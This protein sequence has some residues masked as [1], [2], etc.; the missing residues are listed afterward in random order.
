MRTL[1]LQNSLPTPRR[2]RRKRV[3]AAAITAVILVATSA[4]AVTTVVL[5]PVAQAATPTWM[6]TTMPAAQRAN[7]L[8]AAMTL[9]DKISM[10]HNAPNCEYAGCTPTSFSGGT[11]PALHLQD[12][13]LGVGDGVQ[14]VTQ[15]PAPVAGAATWDTALMR[16]YGTLLG[17][18]HWGKGVNVV[19]GP[20]V[21]IVRD[22]RWGRAFESFGEDPYLAGHIGA[23]EINGIQAEG[24]LAQVKHFVAYNQETNRNTTA[25]NVIASER[26]LREIY[27]PAFEIAI[28]EANVAS[29]MCSY[30]VINGQF[31]CE[32]NHLQ[33]EVLK[34]DMG[35]AGFITA[36]WGGQHSTVASA[37]GGLDMEM[38]DTNKYFGDALKTAVNNGQVSIATIDDHVRRILT[39]MFRFGLF[40]KAQTGNK[41][42]AVTSAAHN[43]TAKKVAAEG[44]VLLKNDGPILPLT[45]AAR[46]IAVIGDAG[47][48]GAIFQGGGS[49]G[50]NSSYRVTPYD[51]IKAR[52]GSG[53]N[54]S[55]YGNDQTAAVAGARAADVAI[56]FAS[57]W[58][59]EGS[60]T[61]DIE[62]GGQNDLISAVAAAN[63]NTIVV[64]NT[65]S[66]VTMPWINS[67]KGVVEAW[68]GGQEYGNALAAV[69][70]GDANP[71]GKLPVTFPRS[72]ADVPANTQAQWPG[73][74]GQVQYSEG[75]NVGYRSYDA[76]NVSPLFPFGFGLSYT[77]FGYSSLIVGQPD[78][79]GNVSVRF[80]VTNT[81]SRAGSEVPQVYVGQPAGIGEPPKSLQGFRKV[82]LAAGASTE[83]NVTLPLRA[84]QHWGATGWTTAGGTHTVSVGASSRDLRINGSVAI[85]GGGGTPTPAR[86]AYSTIEAESFDAQ[87]GTTNEV[88]AD[89]G[90]GQD[91]AYIGNGDTLRFDSID[92]GATAGTKVT[93][94]VA[95]AAAGSPAGTIEVRLDGAT[96]PIAATIP[97][98]G[99]GGWQTWASV[100]AALSSTIGKHSVYL[101]FVTSGGDFVNINWITFGQG[102]TTPT[103]PPTRTTLNRTGW[104]ASASSSAGNDL[105]ANAID[106]NAGSRWSTGTP[107]ANGQTFTVDMGSAKTFDQVSVDAGGSTNDYPRGV[108]VQ[109]S[110]NGTTWNDAATAVAATAKQTVSF[111]A[112]TAQYIRVVQTGVNSSWWSIAELNVLTTGT[113]PTDPTPSTGQ[114]PRA[115]WVASANPASGE[116]PAAAI[117]GNAA[118]RFSSGTA[119][120]NGQTFT[121]DMG[122]AKT[123]NSLTMDSAGSAL[124]YA[125]GYTVQVSSD[126]AGW[127]NVITGTGTSAVVTSRF[128]TQTA[129]FLRVVQTGSSSSWWSIAEFTAANS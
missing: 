43:A 95:S 72:L 66:A 91:V 13:P 71:S 29:M 56:V 19:L 125:R 120:V 25:D 82:A 53:A 106:G 26:T 7:L 115:G 52:A 45:S 122:S 48:S 80:T 10:M 17:R 93:A 14:G 68:Y 61:G 124:D 76:R 79:A 117:D 70:F 36:D 5:A 59:S 92:F 127:T 55:L 84:F 97:V 75:V 46:T 81:G 100:S 111:A 24:P 15:M 98:N 63:P 49:A 108:L 128:T 101:K 110:S 126:G 119:M 99:T 39:Q 103:D 86:S 2:V 9:D 51:G 23:A 107:M 57:K 109:V 77:T 129:R 40:D 31:A 34:R 22:P 123:F 16:E 3:L 38:P 60:D 21:N 94:R 12:G 78:G 114:L 30:S 116:L 112:R 1:P 88:T 6:D 118:S 104:V 85:A 69:L 65:G 58:Q 50:V 32:N 113:T 54:V 62:L 11:L 67:V 105:P 20:T 96:S 4:L 102:P 83:V 18:E 64:L 87:S 44:T 28:K 41:G 37:N 27:L 121:I 42:S 8:L 73:T 89:T 90:G 47:G 74:N 35:F 33:N